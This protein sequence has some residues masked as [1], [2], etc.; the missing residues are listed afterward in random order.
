MVGRAKYALSDK[1]KGAESS[2]GFF[3]LSLTACGIVGFSAS[4]QT[5]LRTRCSKA[6]FGD[7]ILGMWSWGFGGSGCGG[8]V[9]L[10]ILG[11]AVGHLTRY[12][13]NQDWREAKVVRIQHESPI[14]A[15]M[16]RSAVLFSVGRLGTG[17][18]SV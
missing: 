17:K 4:D 13:G 3:E 10:P 5:K 14:D 2:G 9:K 12:D 16:G 8:G 11:E 1:T 7:V 15:A 6:L 18:A